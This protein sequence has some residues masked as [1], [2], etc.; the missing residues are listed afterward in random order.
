MAWPWAL[1]TECCVIELSDCQ[2][3]STCLVLHFGLSINL[4]S[5]MPASAGNCVSDIHFQTVNDVYTGGDAK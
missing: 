2:P 3:V 1:L 4:V 5:D